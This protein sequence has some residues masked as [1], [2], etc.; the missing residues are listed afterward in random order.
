M[1]YKTLHV[2]ILFDDSLDAT[3]R[4]ALMLAKTMDGHVMGRHI[5]HENAYGPPAVFYSGL[6]DFRVAVKDRQ[7]EA[8]GAYARALRAQFED[9][10]DAA[11]VDIIPDTQLPGEARATASWTDTYGTLPHGFAQAARGADLSIM[12]RL[13]PK[14]GALQRDVFES[15]LLNSGRPILAVPTAGLMSLPERIVLAWDGSLPATRAVAGALPLLQ[16]AKDVA[17]V[18]IGEEECRAEASRCV[19]GLRRHGVRAEA[20]RRPL[21]RGWVAERILAEVDDR[22]ANLLV[23]GGYSHTRLHEN[24]LGGVTRHVLG[25]G[26]T[27]LL[28]AH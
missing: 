17:V 20:V 4:T 24:L 12:A 15:L 6:P 9:I 10:C 7:A 18:S 28:M 27:A 16:R 13:G 14:P 22:R 25:H 19:L 23:M 8:A 11:G 26:E 5:R 1:S 3:V 21:D 2:P